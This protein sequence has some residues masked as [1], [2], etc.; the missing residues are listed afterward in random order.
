MTVQRIHKLKAKAFFDK[1]KEETG[2]L[3]TF[4]F[5]CEKKIT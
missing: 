2:G 1:V 5:V 3:K 4:S